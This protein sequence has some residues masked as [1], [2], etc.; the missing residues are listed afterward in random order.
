MRSTFPSER[1]DEHGPDRRRRTS[2]SGRAVTRSDPL[3][4]YLVIATAVVTVVA[5]VFGIYIAY[6]A[7]NPLPPR[8]VQEMQLQRTEAAVKQNPESDEAWAGYAQALTV[9][10]RYTAA[11]NA[12]EDGLKVVPESPPLLVT[13]AGLYYA[14][15]RDE[16]ALATLEELYAAIEDARIAKEESLAERGITADV[17]DLWADVWVEGTL[18]EADVYLRSDDLQGAIDAYTEAL[19]QDPRMADVLTMR[20][21]AYRMMGDIEASRE[22]FEAALRFGPDYE[23]A[24]LGLDS[25]KEVDQ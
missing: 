15:E 5:L 2:N 3:V 14:T 22:D 10:G 20:G 16:D 21:N 9:L 17:S 24:R 6:R 11:E 19:E 4:R 23:P 18:I 7:V 12:I 1:A 8:T 13:R 25:L